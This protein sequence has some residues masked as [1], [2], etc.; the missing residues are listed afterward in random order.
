MR[1]SRT[2]RGQRHEVRADL[3]ASR[4]NTLSCGFI[5][6]ASRREM[7]ST[8]PRIVSTDSREDSML[9]TA[10]RIGPFGAFSMRD[11]V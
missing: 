3:R 9:P 4:R 11:E 5:A 2:W 8:A 7:S 6:P 10:S 1:S